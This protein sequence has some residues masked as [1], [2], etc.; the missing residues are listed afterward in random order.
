M[1]K[2]TNIHGSVIQLS[3]LN[4]RIYLMKLNQDKIGELLPQL[5][6]IC[7]KREYTKIFA[8]IPNNLKKEFENECY[9]EEAFVK[10]YFLDDDAI[11]MSKYF[12]KDRKIS[13]FPEKVKEV[14]NVAE[15][16][17][18]IKSCSNLD[19]NFSLGVV[20]KDDAGELANL[21][22]KVFE[23]YP[24]PIYDPNYIIKMMNSNVVYF[25]IKHSGKIV[26]AA[27]SEINKENRCVEMTDFAVLPEYQGHRL[28]QQL[29]FAM[30]DEMRNKGIRVAYT[31]ARALSLG[32]NITF[33]KLGYKYTGT[34]VNNTNICGKL[35]DMNVW[36]K[37][38]K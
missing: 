10:G 1:D 29:L 30:E 2:I 22:K 6:E 26:A 25:A 9:V 11:F 38:L 7:V 36:Y 5:N 4:D 27:S 8:V 15:N 31:I 32:M 16:K 12:S 34:L 20:N 14:L 3:D 33:A 21:Y 35:E 28:A 17:R 24:F 23:T 18:P 19:S 13:R 37:H